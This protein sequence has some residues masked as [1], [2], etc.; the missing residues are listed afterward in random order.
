MAGT[1][2]G[3]STTPIGAK[4]YV[5]GKLVATTPYGA[6]WFK[7]GDA[8]RIEL[9]GYKTLSFILTS[10]RVGKSN[11]YLLETEAAIP[12]AAKTYGDVQVKSSPTNAKVYVD[13]R[14][15][16][17]TT[18]ALLTLETGLRTITL[19]KDGYLDLQWVETIRQE[20]RVLSTKF[21]TQVPIPAPA[22][23]Q[24]PVPIQA[25]ETIPE[26][27]VRTKDIVGQ[28]LKRAI[29]DG[30]LWDV[31]KLTYEYLTAPMPVPIA[32]DYISL[33]LGFM[34]FGGGAKFINLFDGNADDAVKIFKGLNI[35]GQAKLVRELVKSG[36][37]INALN[38][39]MKKDALNPAMVRP[40]ISAIDA[41][42][43]GMI[44][45]FSLMSLKEMLPWLGAAVAVMGTVNFIEFLYEE[46]LQTQGMGIYVAIANKQWAVAKE[47]LDKARGNLEK[48]T[49]VYT[50]IGWLAP[51]AW[52]VFKSYA[53]ATKLQYDSY[54]KVIN[55]KLAYA[56]APDVFNKANFEEDVKKKE[57]PVPEDLVEKPVEEKKEEMVKVITPEEKKE[58]V[59][60]EVPE[61]VPA[62]E[63]KAPVAAMPTV[64]EFYMEIGTYV[65]EG[66]R[67]TR[68]EWEA[69][70]VKYG[71]TQLGDVPEK[72]ETIQDL[73]LIVGTYVVG[74][75]VLTEKEWEE[76]AER[77]VL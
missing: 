53:A 3:I 13:R 30:R 29:A 49:W 66:K 8:I 7:G 40:A 46:M 14:N 62:E 39:L 37:G 55:S 73:Y 36:K 11:Y 16:G 5:N 50:N 72:A 56:K 38:Y 51:Y 25:P 2:T 63:E 17:K 1:L 60:I 12:P 23:A 71:L 44:R 27:T 54:E 31:V 48:A 41:A 32:E 68:K 42:V 26:P 47:T 67:L 65:T 58:E 76:L 77:P 45:G 52:D 21:L 9:A 15:T 74:K 69:I 35:E 34:S 20:S 75:A 6:F 22:P 43:K 19:K 18:P 4:L 28:D 59:P 70:G 33:M 61:A 10:D 57:V 24:A 64:R